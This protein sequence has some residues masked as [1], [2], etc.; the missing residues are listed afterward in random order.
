M[1]DKITYNGRPIV[2]RKKKTKKIEKNKR[3]FKKGI[4]FNMCSVL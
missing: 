1:I 2:P 3:N 4:D